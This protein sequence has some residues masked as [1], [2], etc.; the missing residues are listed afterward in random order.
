MFHGTPGPASTP[1][2]SQ[3]RGRRERYTESM[4]QPPAP[5]WIEPESPRGR[6]TYIDPS[7]HPPEEP[8]SGFSRGPLLGEG[9]MGVVWSAHQT[10]L[11]RE[12]AIKA[13][14]PEAGP[15]AVRALIDEARVTG[16]LEHPGIVPVHDLVRGDAG[17]PWLVMKRLA[18]TVWSDLLAETHHP[19]WERHEPDPE[20]R[21]DVHLGVLLR[22]CDTLAFAHD[23]GVIHRDI[24]PANVMI[25]EYGEVV[26]LDWGI[27]LAAGQNGA[28]GFP[29]G[30]PGYFAPEMATGAAQD[31][32]TDVWLLGAT[33]YEVLTGKPPN[34]GTRLEEWRAAATSP[35]RELPESPAELRD[36]VARAMQ[37][38]PAQRYPSVRALGSAIQQFLRGRSARPLAAA[39]ETRLEL[40]RDALRRGDTV[41]A[42]LRLAEARFGFERAAS[43]WPAATAG[44]DAVLATQ[45]EV[46]VSD[47]A[48]PG[49]RAVLAGWREAPEAARQLVE[50]L[51]AEI[52]AEAAEHER[53]TALAGRLDASHNTAARTGVMAALLAAAIAIAAALRA[54]YP[55]AI[56]SVQ[57]P[58]FA[59]GVPLAV[60]PIV[61]FAAWWTR[62]RTRDDPFTRH[63]LWVTAAALTAIAA[64]RS[65]AWSSGMMLVTAIQFDILL[66]ITIFCT[67][68]I[69]A[70]RPALAIAAGQVPLLALTVVFPEYIDLLELSTLLPA[71]VVSA[72]TRRRGGT[73]QAT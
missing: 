22:L 8:E 55:N 40:A 20:A 59:I 25:G 52:A 6:I 49:A 3:V 26:L 60:A 9:G 4:A 44:R 63:V 35:N 47:R 19:S 2:A 57:T 54:V 18:G 51:A 21:L 46:E 62:E 45:L 73:R 48:L 66:I 67:F 27:A 64:G 30:T 42:R 13:A 15:A 36:V 24:K 70:W 71:L 38:E 56:H 65:L 11:G 1:L 61:G 10:T 14:R 17:A 34:E 50:R 43:D 28:N 72:R 37:V 32:R 16:G 7:E 31:A 33:L 29:S 39:A 5:T 41:T 68:G 58:L 23:R 69:V 53:V 12:V